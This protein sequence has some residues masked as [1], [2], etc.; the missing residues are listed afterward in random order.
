MA[1][2]GRR[3]AVLRAFLSRAKYHGDRQ[4]SRLSVR[5][6]D[7][8]AY[9]GPD[10]T[11]RFTVFRPSSAAHVQ[12][13]SSSRPLTTHAQHLPTA[14]ESLT[15]PV[16]AVC[17]AAGARGRRAPA[18]TVGARA[19]SAPRAMSATV[20]AGSGGAAA[21]AATTRAGRGTSSL[22]AKR[23]PE[24]RGARARSRRA[25]R[26]RSRAA[27]RRGGSRRTAAGRSRS[28]EEWGPAKAKRGHLAGEGGA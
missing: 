13:L 8:A 20:R 27:G 24:R 16:A 12:H 26:R 21:L 7:A 25:R 1:C 17:A 19:A 18:A 14:H 10:C 11:L 3:V 22:S 23:R 5:A 28:G 9:N 4:I 2:E 6:R 15:S